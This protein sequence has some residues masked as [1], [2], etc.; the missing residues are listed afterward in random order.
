MNDKTFKTTVVSLLALLI[1]AMGWVAYDLSQ[2]KAMLNVHMGLVLDEELPPLF[3][4]ELLKSK[5]PLAIG[6]AMTAF[7][8]GLSVL[9]LISDRI[10]DLD[11]DHLAQSAEVDRKLEYT[12]AQQR[13]ILSKLS[14]VETLIRDLE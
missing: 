9:K 14:F 8:V 6:Q 7:N 5:K 3:S 13:K 1:T 12:K 10:D 11:Q 4:D 2:T